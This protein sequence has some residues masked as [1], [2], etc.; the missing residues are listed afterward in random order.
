MTDNLRKRIAAVQLNHAALTLDD[1]Q[2]W[3][4]G[5]K[6][7]CLCGHLVVGDDLEQIFLKWADHVADAVIGALGVRQE[8][9]FD[10]QS[11]QLIGHRYVTEWKGHDHY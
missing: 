8:A 9:A 10:S 5:Q 6:Q 3:Q 4:E 7:Q 2:R 11:G 1:L